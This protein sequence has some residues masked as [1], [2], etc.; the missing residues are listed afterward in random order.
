MGTGPTKPGSNFAKIE[1]LVS[2]LVDVLDVWCRGR[3]GARG[4]G[5]HLRE[6]Y[7]AIILIKCLFFL[8]KLRS[9]IGCFRSSNVAVLINALQ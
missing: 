4:V 2:A 5:R 6:K 3:G 9:E 7:D 1:T 8:M